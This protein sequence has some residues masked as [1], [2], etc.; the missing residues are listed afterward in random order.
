MIKKDV[1]Y[2]IAVG[3]FAAH[4]LVVSSV[5]LAGELILGVDYM[6]GSSVLSVA[7]YIFVFVKW[8]S[9]L[10]IVISLVNGSFVHRKE[11]YFVGAIATAL[12]VFHL[13][14]VFYFNSQT[15]NEILITMEADSLKNI[16][17]FALY[18]FGASVVVRNNKKGELR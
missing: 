14:Y 10:L 11:S 5:F 1:L 9:Q 7:V 3:F 15:I 6:M 4:L 8:I 2:R 13:S 18:V 16:A 12:C 17:L